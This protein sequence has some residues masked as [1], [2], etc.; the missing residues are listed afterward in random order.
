[1]QNPEKLYTQKAFFVYMCCS[2]VLFV[3]LMFTSIPPLYDLFNVEP[4]KAEPLWIIGS[5]PPR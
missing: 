3:V 1:V 2:T 5:Q 4:N